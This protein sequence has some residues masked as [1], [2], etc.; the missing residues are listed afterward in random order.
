MKTKTKK[1]TIGQDKCA[2]ISFALVTLIF[3]CFNVDL[4]S[5]VQWNNTI[6]TGTYSSAIGSQTESTGNFSFSAG[7]LTKAYGISSIS[8]GNKSVADGHYSMSLGESCFSGSQSYSLGRMQKQK[9]NNH[10]QSVDLLKQPQQV[11]I[12][13]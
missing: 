8:L 12:H 1:V 10:L 3:L 11:S 13:L 7:L 9:D 5:Q 6:I 4:Y 2:L